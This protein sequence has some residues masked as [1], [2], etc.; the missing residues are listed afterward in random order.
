MLSLRAITGAQLNLM[1]FAAV[2]IKRIDDRHMLL[3]GAVDRATLL[4]IALDA[5]H[6]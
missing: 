6:Q 3:T 4:L 1:R 5:I 2:G